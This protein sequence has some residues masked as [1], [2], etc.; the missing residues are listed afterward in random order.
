MS[1]MDR[2]EDE[3]ARQGALLEELSATLTLLE[4][5]LDHL[6]TDLVA[7]RGRMRLYN[8]LC[9]PATDQE[10]APTHEEE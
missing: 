9:H 8:P 5:N 6:H 1:A 7:I 2:I 3:L 4:S 10:P